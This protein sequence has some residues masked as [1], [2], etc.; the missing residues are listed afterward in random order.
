METTNSERIS[1]IAATILLIIGMMYMSVQAAEDSRQRAA[2]GRG[3]GRAA[4]ATPVPQ[5]TEEELSDE[6]LLGMLGGGTN[7]PAGGNLPTGGGPGIRPTGPTGPTGPG[8]GPTPRPRAT[9]SAFQDDPSVN[10]AGTGQPPRPGRYVYRDTDGGSEFTMR[11]E[12]MG[13][14]RYREHIESGDAPPGFE[15]YLETVWSGS[16]KTLDK[17]VT[18]FQAQD[19]SCDFQPDVTAYPFELSRGRSWQNDSS[20]TV[21]SPMGQQTQNY[22]GTSA[23]VG[24][25]RVEVA[26]RSVEVWVIESN[27]QSS[28]GGPSGFSR[29]YFSP[30][31]GVSVRTEG[32][33]GGFGSGNSQLQNLDPR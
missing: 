30:E 9:P 10:P 3:E 18:K 11:M 7:D 23:V 27:F 15:L 24:A 17:V 22:R 1:L 29:D 28:G 26:G 25:A 12:Q 19:Y 31:H 6:D 21:N 32:Q 14:G 8:G 13:G 33:A 2:A 16:S 4:Q 20:C 5:A